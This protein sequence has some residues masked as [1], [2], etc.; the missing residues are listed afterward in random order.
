MALWKQAQEGVELVRFDFGA[1]QAPVYAH[2]SI[3]T[4]RS[5]VFAMM[6]SNEN[7]QEAR[8][9]RVRIRDC[10]QQVFQSF[11]AYLYGQDTKA[12]DDGRV[13]WELADKVSCLVGEYCS[14]VQE[15]LCC[16]GAHLPS[17]HLTR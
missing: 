15:S 13:M 11:I 12:E 16:K 3:L 2:R 7:F 8:T 10:P 1:G 17:S 6:L 14:H 4:L 5:N 9:G